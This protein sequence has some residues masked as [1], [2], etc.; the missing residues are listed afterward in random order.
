MK[1]LIVVIP[2]YNEEKNILKVLSELSNLN[3]DSI[4]VDDGSTD[5]TKRI[6]KEYI[7]KTTSNNNN[8]NKN[9]NVK[10]YTIFK[11]T[12][13]GKAKA[14]EQG[15]K[16]ALEKGYKYICYI[17]GDYQHKPKDI[18]P[19]FEKLKKKDAD[20]VFGIRRYKHIPF[21]RII[22]NYLAS[23]FMSVMVS[24]YALNF[25]IFKDIQSGF[26]IIKGDFLNDMYF[27]DGY[28]VEH[29][30]ALQLAKRKAKIV[31]EY[32]SI[33]YHPNAISYITTKKIIDVVKEVAKFIL[34]NK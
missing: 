10:I 6:V 21:Y 5:N 20:A 3:L 16:F 34:H 11:S 32:I 9:N 19:M 30:V 26:R 23:V 29:L 4:V 12:N 25:H 7:D 1:N 27:G 18:L 24:I 17:D 33:E 2:A 14:L 22:S 31:E 15:T 28:S 13:E 8:K